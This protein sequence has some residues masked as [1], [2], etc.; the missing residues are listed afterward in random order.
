M[1]TAMADVATAAAA[2]PARP[3][4]PLTYVYALLPWGDPAVAA[5]AAGSITGIEGAQVRL[6]EQDGLAAAVGNVPA[7][8]FEEVALNRRLRDLAW[9]GPRA[10][11]HQAVNAQLF[12]LAGALLPLAFGT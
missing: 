9:L 8:E 4:A 11:A 3:A 12:A 6:V 1:A 5:I 7:G 2:G 10:A